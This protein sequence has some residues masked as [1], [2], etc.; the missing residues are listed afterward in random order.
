MHHLAS[1]ILGYVHEDIPDLYNFK[2]NSLFIAWFS[3]RWRLH[4]THPQTRCTMLTLHCSLLPIVRCAQFLTRGQQVSH[5]EPPIPHWVKSRCTF[6]IL[7]CTDNGLQFTEVPFESSHPESIKYRSLF[8][9]M[10]G[11]L[12]LL[13]TIDLFTSREMRSYTDMSI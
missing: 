2:L 9:S 10:C 1:Q 11:A 5:C 3:Y 8:L 4:I 12:V 13:V 7:C 6:C